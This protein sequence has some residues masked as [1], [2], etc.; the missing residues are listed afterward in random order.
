M[1]DND[2]EKTIE[3]PENRIEYE[4]EDFV[5]DPGDELDGKELNDEELAA[6]VGGGARIGGTITLQNSFFYDSSYG[7]AVCG[8]ANGTYTIERYIP[9]RKCPYA[10][11]DDIGLIH[12][13]WVKN[14]ERII[15]FDGV[16]VNRG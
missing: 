15:A 6:V 1:S 7:D 8:R 12:Y 2:V 5:V 14:N 9:G 13:G 3:S 11:S 4:R 16:P 10:L